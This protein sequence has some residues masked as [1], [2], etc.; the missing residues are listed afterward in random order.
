M[1][2]NSLYA[3][4]SYVQQIF[5]V[6]KAKTAPQTKASFFKIFIFFL[7]RLLFYYQTSIFKAKIT[8]NYGQFVH[9]AR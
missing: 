9:P 8:V 6:T 7:R 1:P 5:I 4:S 2:K 3:N